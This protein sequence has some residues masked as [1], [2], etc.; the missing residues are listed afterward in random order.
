MISSRLF[1]N[2]INISANESPK[3]FNARNTFSNNVYFGYLSINGIFYHCVY[4]WERDCVWSSAHVFFL[5]Y[6]FF[7][8][9]L[10]ISPRV[11]V[12][13]GMCAYRQRTK[14]NDKSIEYFKGNSA[15]KINGIF[16]KKCKVKKKRKDLY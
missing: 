11:I 12:F 8:I 14:D 4:R 13:A 9:Y 2:H 6:I 7:S 5:M 15:R 16:Y 3:I 10:L 1:P